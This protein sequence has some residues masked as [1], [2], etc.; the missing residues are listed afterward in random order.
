MTAD[1]LL[2]AVLADPDDDGP[3][4]VLA[5]WLEEHGHRDRAE[6][7]RVQIELARLPAKD[8]RRRRLLKR[9]KEL[10]KQHAE[11]WGRM[12]WP[13]TRLGDQW[14]FRRGFIEQVE[15]SAVLWVATDLIADLMRQAPIRCLRFYTDGVA[16]N[17]PGLVKVAPHLTRLTAL[18]LYA[19]P[20]E[21][22]KDRKALRE[23][24]QSPHLS[25]LTTLRVMGDGFDGE[26]DRKTF[27]AAVT[28]PALTNLRELSLYQWT[29]G[30]E[31]ANLRALARSPHLPRLEDLDLRNSGPISPAAW[32]FLIRSPHRAALR[33]LRLRE[34]VIPN[35]AGD[36]PS[37][38]L[39][40]HRPLV[41]EL[42][43]R[44][45]KEGL[46]F[47]SAFQLWAGHR[48]SERPT[49]EQPPC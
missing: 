23:L 14:A 28:S 48:W 33:K 12:V 25:G 49:W 30:L 35:P 4:L 32:R 43:A 42:E 47:D 39:H 29:E 19:F 7:I 27:E 24:F 41:E 16:L 8:P 40:E 5:D 17:L 1:D 44:F 6:F 3:R 26:I 45:G 11:Y 9:E 34:S 36:G 21:G 13:A 37:L 20:V 18:E 31:E 10:L 2:D 15:V 46:D 38:W 22:L